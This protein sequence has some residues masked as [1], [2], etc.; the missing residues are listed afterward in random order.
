[1]LA[2]KVTA[3]AAVPETPEFLLEQADV[4]FDASD[5]A[6]AEQLYEQARVA[7][8]D[9]GKLSVE[10][11]ATSQRARCY[12]TQDIFDSAKV[13]LD[14]AEEIAT[15]DQPAGW[16][17]FLGVKG[18]WQWRNDNNDEAV[19]TFTTMYEFA[20]E[21]DLSHHQI[22]A[23]RMVAIVAP[24]QR[25]E[26]WALKGI[27]LAEESGSEKLLGPLWNNLGG[28]YCD[29]KRYDDAVNAYT[30]ARGYHWRFGK[31]MNKFWADYSVGYAL[32]L[33]GKHDDAMSWFNPCLAWAERMENHAA[34]GHTS[35]QVGE[36]YLVRGDTTKCLT[37]LK[38]ALLH[39][40]E[41]GYAEHSA[42]VIEGIEKRIA[43]LE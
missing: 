15:P 7:A 42:S 20:D 29:L 17:R 32:R 14:K 23:A 28:T 1:L 31:E 36:V 38:S 41:A 3:V 2:T 9:A 40:R 37:Y 35:E 39:Y 5:Y 25:Q 16:A 26:E 11:E 18:R 30:N 43:E 34:I 13:W 24:V 21:H 8:R 33:A 19:S 27:E 4:A 10:I 22:D 6:T 12:L